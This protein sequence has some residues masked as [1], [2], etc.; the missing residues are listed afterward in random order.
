M[1]GNRATCLETTTI[2]GMSLKEF[3]TTEQLN[4]SVSMFGF[5]HTKG[6]AAEATFSPWNIIQVEEGR[7]VGSLDLN[8]YSLETTRSHAVLSTCS[9]QLHGA[10]H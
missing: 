2:Q 7:Q 3:N 1:R 10:A 4:A 8:V 5:E 9:A 6:L